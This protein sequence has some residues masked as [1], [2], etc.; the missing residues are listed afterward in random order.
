MQ[1][2]ILLQDDRINST[3]EVLQKRIEDRFPSCGLA[4]LCGELLSVSQ[5]ASVRATWIG[6]RVWWIRLAGYLMAALLIALLVGVIWYVSS[7][8]RLMEGEMSF[9]GIITNFDA[10][11]SGALLIGAA[12]YFLIS[13]EIR[14]KR[15]RALSAIHELRSIAHVVDMHQLTKD[16]ERTFRRYKLTNHSPVRTMTPQELSRYLDYCTEM[17]SLIGKI[18]ALYI[19]RFDDPVAVAAVSEVEQLTTGLSRKIWQKIVI[20]SQNSDPSMIANDAHPGN[21]LKPGVGVSKTAVEV[22]TPTETKRES[23]SSEDVTEVN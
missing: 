5:K 13:L 8:V 14:I 7:S 11:T 15:R 9:T 2:K 1:N 16:P 12:L 6:K 20:L 21:P 22:N 10:A 17:L 23:E 19:Q 4:Q 3:V 18:A